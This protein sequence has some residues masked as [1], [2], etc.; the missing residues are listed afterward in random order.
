VGKKLKGCA[1]SNAVAV[2]AKKVMS[3]TTAPNIGYIELGWLTTASP[4]SVLVWWNLLVG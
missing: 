2:F 1:I 3:G 4:M